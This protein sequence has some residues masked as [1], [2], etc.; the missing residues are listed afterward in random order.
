ME[1]TPLDPSASA[2][3]VEPQITPTPASP[4]KR[5]MEMSDAER[6]EWKLTGTRPPK[7]A[8]EPDD[9]DEAIAPTAP[10]AAAPET[11][12]PAPSKPISKRQQQIN[13][14][15]RR[16]AESTAEIARLKAFNAM[17]SPSAPAP[18]PAPSPQAVPAQPQTVDALIARP[19]ISGP[20]LTPEQFFQKFPEADVWT[21][22]R[23]INK[24]DTAFE[25]AES[26]QQQQQAAIRQQTD[27]HVAQFTARVQTA[28]QKYPDFESKG[29]A[30]A[31]RME[32]PDRGP[33]E[34]AVFLSPVGPD[35][36]QHFAEHQDELQRLY[37]I[38]SRH[39]RKDWADAE[40]LF[41]IGKIAARF[42]QPAR[43]QAPLPTTSA[44]D[45][46]IALG[47]RATE[48]VEPLTTAIKRR[49]FSTYKQL[50]NSR[51]LARYR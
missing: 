6:Q 13:D 3:S 48:P 9:A 34:N 21:Y 35:L 29:M 31:L 17:R 5:P 7:E 1:S 16:L 24:Y 36:L 4:V 43:A 18:A 32:G 51:D 12:A 37:Q 10:V 15:E 23:Y 30:L 14:Y 25:R 41:E 44:P 11:P 28:R 22:P 20:A 40:I 49:D 2:Q 50:A 8:A 46:P 38:P 39:S 33:I 19:D 27:E 45:P 42:D 47:A 26:H